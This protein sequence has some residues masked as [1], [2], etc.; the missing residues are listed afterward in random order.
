MRRFASLFLAAALVVTLPGCTEFS[1][2]FADSKPQRAVKHSKAK[3]NYNASAYVKSL[4]LAQIS[5]EDN[6]ADLEVVNAYASQK[7]K[8]QGVVVVVLEYKTAGTAALK[9]VLAPVALS[10]KSEEFPDL[11]EVMT[12]L[13][14]KTYTLH[15]IYVASTKTSPDKAMKI[16]DDLTDE[17]LKDA[18]AAQQQR[19]LDR[20]KRLAAIDH[21]RAQLR[22]IPF[23][24]NHR[25]RDAAYL[26]ADDARKNLADLQGAA[27]EETQK[28][29][30][31]QLEAYEAEMRK[32]MPFTL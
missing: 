8:E 3:T 14:R 30:S 10:G 13:E 2:L 12:R 31:Q 17:A 24:I 29:L 18:L 6:A 26:T 32:D 16:P 5:P 20:S 4:A 11:L 15:N 23:F 22:L 7:P 21:M 1:K 25:F 9:R 19:L 28:S 27:N